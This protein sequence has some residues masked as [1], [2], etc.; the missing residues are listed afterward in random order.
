MGLRGDRNMKEVY[1]YDGDG[2]MSSAHFLFVTGLG[3]GIDYGNLGYI[4]IL[5]I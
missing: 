5:V 4:S 1:E 2:Y 3:V